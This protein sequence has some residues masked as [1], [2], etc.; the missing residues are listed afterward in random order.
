[1]KICV[2]GAGVAGL[3]ALR[4]IQSIPGFEGV[5][6]EQTADIGGVWSDLENQKQCFQTPMYQ[7]LR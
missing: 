7:G 5:V 2:I 3:V 6:Y 4:R 1:M